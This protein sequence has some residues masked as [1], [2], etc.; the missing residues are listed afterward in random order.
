MVEK[1]HRYHSR[2]K[3]CRPRKKKLQAGEKF[4]A[5]LQKKFCRPAKFFL[6]ACKKFFPGLQFFFSR[7]T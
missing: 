2:E 1:K 5:G 4:F 7:P 3:L 6:Q